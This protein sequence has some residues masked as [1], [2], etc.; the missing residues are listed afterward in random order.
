VRFSIAVACVLVAGVSAQSGFVPAR[1]RDGAVP[2]LPALPLGGGQVFLELTVGSDG[3]VTA[4]TPLRTTPPFTDLV[5]RAVRGWHFDPAEEETEPGPGQPV[6][7]KLR[8]RVASKVLVAGQFRP[9]TTFNNATLGEPAKDVSSEADET[10]FPLTTTMPVFPPFALVRGVVL[11][12]A[13]IDRDGAVTEATVIRSARPFDDVAVA[14]ARQWRFRPA[15][16]GGRSVESLAYL[17]F[18]F[19]TPVTGPS[20]PCAEPGVPPPLSPP[21]CPPPSPCA[22]R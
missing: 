1:Y 6:A 5:A 2:P 12:Q 3:R 17:L 14:A 19:P 8:R 18:G 10:P 22:P 9:P 13:R 16:V 15:R 4:V 21:G 20:C 11:V 7:P